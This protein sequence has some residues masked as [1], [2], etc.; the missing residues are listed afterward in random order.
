MF[1]KKN[2]WYRINTKKSSACPTS[3]LL[4]LHPEELA[5]QYPQDCF[6]EVSRDGESNGGTVWIHQLS[7]VKTQG[8]RLHFSPRKRSMTHGYPDLQLQ[9]QL[10]IMIYIIIHPKNG[11]S[12][13]CILPTWDPQQYTIPPNPQGAIKSHPKVG[14][15]DPLWK[16]NSNIARPCLCAP[17]FK[18]HSGTYNLLHCYTFVYA[19]SDTR[20]QRQLDF[21]RLLE[22]ETHAMDKSWRSR[23]EHGDH[24][25]KTAKNSNSGVTSMNQA[26]C[27]KFYPWV[28]ICHSMPCWWCSYAFCWMFT[29]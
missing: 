5:R 11:L 2:R 27:F 24:E 3:N 17:L 19:S 12:L 25:P 22:P 14:V 6:L 9:L 21:L 8:V 7:T 20:P 15:A 26:G 13:G 1:P 10:T 18:M 28:M 23:K 16:G 4:L 29:G